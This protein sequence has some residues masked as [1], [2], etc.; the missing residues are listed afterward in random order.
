[1]NSTV[2]QQISFEDATYLK[3]SRKTRKQKFLEEMDKAMPWKKW[4]AVI[5]PHYPNGK[6]G[7]RPFPL[8]TMLR[9]H[10]MQQW[11]GLSDPGMED[12]L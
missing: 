8:E 3:R 7:R 9:I 2:I 6:R 5:E 10:F 12:E 11:F 4:V 1:M